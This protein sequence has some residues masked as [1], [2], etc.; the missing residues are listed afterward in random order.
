M[1]IT[2]W[3]AHD[4]SLS[5]A[6]QSVI[7]QSI[8]KRGKDMDITSENISRYMRGASEE[9]YPQ[10]IADAFLNIG[11]PDISMKERMA[12]RKDLENAL[13]DLMAMAQNEYN[14]DYWRV[15]WNMIQLVTATNEEV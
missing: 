9:Y 13:Y 7:T 12:I 15:L 11:L 14:S 4:G 2:L 8:L 5:W 3:V 6:S 10:E 1:M